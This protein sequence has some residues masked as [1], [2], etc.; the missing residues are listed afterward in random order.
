MA[1]TLATIVAISCP[2]AAFVIGR[3]FD[4]IGPIEGN[5]E[6]FL[7]STW[8]MACA[9]SVIGAIVMSRV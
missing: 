5:I 1:S 2:V 7:F 8:P 3:W 6:R 4:R 9:G